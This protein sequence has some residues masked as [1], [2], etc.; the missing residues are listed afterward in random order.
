MAEDLGEMPHGASHDLE[1]LKYAENWHHYL[2]VVDL[3]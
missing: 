3:G 2:L 1:K